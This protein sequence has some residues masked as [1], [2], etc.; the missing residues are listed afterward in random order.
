VLAVV[1]EA[2]A[3]IGRGGEAER[4]LARVLA[5]RSPLGLLAE[6]VDPLPARQ[7][8]NVPQA[9]VGLIHAALAASPRL[10]EV[11]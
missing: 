10:G 3:A 11:V 2:L 7:W 1:R 4:M 6:D 9:H 5:A 8:G